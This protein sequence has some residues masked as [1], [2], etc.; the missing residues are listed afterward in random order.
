MHNISVNFLSL[1][2]GFVD[3]DGYIKITKTPKGYIRLGLVINLHISE[4]P[5]IEYLKNILKI[6]RINI[7]PKRKIVQ[8]NI[9]RTDKQEILIPLIIFHKLK[10]L[11]YNR[12]IQYEKLINILKNN[13]LKFEQIEKEIPYT[14]QT[15]TT[16]K[17]V[18]NINSWQIGFIMAEGSF[19]IKKDKSF[20]FSIKQEKKNI[21]L[22]E[23]IAKN[24]IGSTT[25]I[26]DYKGYIQINISSKK[27]IKNKIKI[28]ENNISL[29]GLKL[30]QYTDWKN[31]KRNSERYKDCL[32]D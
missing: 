25:K 21:I 7:Y 22:F 23:Y 16:L 13:I 14:P 18:L 32:N 20:N 31:K 30:I 27:D 10:F 5:L 12:S 3:G 9:S 17:N 2:K 28:I 6:G 11:T 19:N 26:N 1:F 15:N 8:L 4:L 29:K 24:I